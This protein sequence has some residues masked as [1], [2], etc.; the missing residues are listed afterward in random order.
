MHSVHMANSLTPMR[1]CLRTERTIIPARDVCR[2]V[3]TKKLR[4]V[5]SFLGEHQQTGSKQGANVLPPSVIS[6]S[7]GTHITLSWHI[8]RQRSSR[9]CARTRT[10]MEVVHFPS[11]LDSVRPLLQPPV[12]RFFYCTPPHLAV[13]CDFHPPPRCATHANVCRQQVVVW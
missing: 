7:A 12:G 13:C 11:W 4:R 5:R 1:A 8:L 2:R 10:I 3:W 9:I 6:S